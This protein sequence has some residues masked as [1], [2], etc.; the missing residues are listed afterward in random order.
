MDSPDMALEVRTRAEGGSA[1]SGTCERCGFAVVVFV[2]RSRCHQVELATDETYAFVDGAHVRLEIRFFGKRLAAARDFAPYGLFGRPSG[3]RLAS[4]VLCLEVLL[5]LRGT[6]EAA[7]VAKDA[8]K[9]LVSDV[10]LQLSQGPEAQPRSLGPRFLNPSLTIMLVTVFFVVML[11]LAISIVIARCQYA[12]ITPEGKVAMLFGNM[13]AELYSS[14]KGQLA[15]GNGATRT[16]LT[17]SPGG[18]DLPT[19][20][21]LEPEVVR[22]NMSQ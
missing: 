5:E 12:F 15:R 4:R 14:V 11:V 16:R 1:P 3:A 20:K 2:A 7:I 6:R 18:T 10:L 22:P 21:R 19:D 17:G 13:P 8:I 9:M